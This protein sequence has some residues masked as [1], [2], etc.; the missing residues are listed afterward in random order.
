ML[1]QSLCDGLQRAGSQVDIA[2]DAPAASLALT[3]HGYAAVLL[4]LGLPLGS[5]LQVLRRM[6][7][8]H[9]TTPVVIITARDRLA[10][11]IA[12]L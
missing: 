12:G 7:E 5:G 6:R 4:D 8:R 11:R 1:A 2:P 10:D 3:E 9:D